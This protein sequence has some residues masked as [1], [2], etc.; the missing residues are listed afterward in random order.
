MTEQ[1]IG[2]RLLL[3]LVLFMDGN[4]KLLIFGLDIFILSSFSSK[5]FGPSCPE[6]TRRFQLDFS[7]PSNQRP[8]DRASRTRDLCH[9]FET[10]TNHN[11]TQRLRICSF[12]I[13][14][15]QKDFETYNLP[16]IS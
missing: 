5:E 13:V 3:P 8:D 7:L 6:S 16:H 14:G 12:V 4:G 1:D 15:L 9:C 10:L 11:N 2:G